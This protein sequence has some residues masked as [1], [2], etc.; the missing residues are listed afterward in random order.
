M[1]ET[2]DLSIYVTRPGDGTAHLD[3][4][5][6]GI[7]CAACI[8]DIEGGLCRLPGIVDARLNYTNHRLAV[9]WRDGAFSPSQVVEELGRLGY[10]AHPF[11][12][13]LVEEEEA[14]RAQ[15]LLRC[16]AVAGFASMN[17]MLLAVSV[18]SGNVTDITPETRDFF[19]W[20]AALIALPAVAYAGRPFFQSAMS[21]LRNRRTN[22]DVPIVIGILLALS[23]S[24][25]ETI[26]SAEHTYFDS[27]VMLLF[28]L[29]CGRYLDQA[30]RRKT[31][32]VAS[33]LASLRAEV[34][35][36]IEDNGEIVLLPT[37]AVKTGDR[38]LV[39]PGERIAVDGIVLSGSSDV[40]E[41][42]V[43]G[44]TAHRSVSANSQIYAGSMNHSGTLTLRVTAAGKGTLLDEV[45]RLL[46]NAA[47]AKSRYV[48]LADR[49]ARIYAPVVHTAAAVT[50]LTWIATGASVHDALLT[51]IAV[52]IITC[53]CALALAVPV[54]QV[55][56]SGALFRAGVFLNAGDAFERLA[57]VDTIVFDKTGTL[58][59]PT[60]SVTNA[61]DVEPALLAAA[62]RLALSSH[63]PL[64]AA[65]ARM[66]QDRRPYHDVAE[67]P[68]QGVRAVVN[69]MEMRLGSA[70]F[71][72][73]EDT[74]EKAASTDPNAS[75]IA[76]SWGEERA[77]L[78]VRQA[79]RPDAAA[80]VRNLRGRGFDCRIL[81]GDRPEAVAPIAAALGIATWRG[82]CKP[83][84]KIRALDALKSEGRKVLMVGD[85]LNDAPA[86]AAAHVSLSPISAADLTQA[87]ADA[88]F[89]GDRLQPVQD[90]IDIARRAHRLMRQNLGIALVYNLIAVPLAFLGFVT[91]LVAALAMSGSSTLVTL[92]ALRARGRASE[93]QPEA[94]QSAIVPVTQGA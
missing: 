24:V 70:A 32:A 12:A 8:E 7:D 41:S 16:L 21:A 67:E 25:F 93:P 3:L 59:L 23:V 55:V 44:E 2:L 51:A 27:V 85:G 40:D 89:L 94:A 84:D 82:G 38:V 86:L 88:V 91:P 4:A 69:G 30:M 11:R 45:E 47:A 72:G 5:V 29:L 66:A 48:Q 52:L 90:T 61:G 46:E 76:F 9:E 15:W 87:H 54:V 73:A 14:R 71:C 1:S 35:H 65:V 34:V 57:K 81:S 83:T 17:I 78:L 64:A 43:T 60:M 39:R 75:V 79:L 37:A 53:P 33:N 62:S 26:S 49:V 68:G 22:M 92:N 31:R 58:T 28:F 50:A 74:A 42:L 63:H 10:R 80:I 6:E 13:R 20:L 36:R 19:H 77:A 18:W 56:A